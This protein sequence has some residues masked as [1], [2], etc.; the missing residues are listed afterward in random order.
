MVRILLD[1]MQ[2]RYQ[3]TFVAGIDDLRD[4]RELRILRDRA[5]VRLEV[6][7]DMER[8]AAEHFKRNPAG[9]LAWK[10]AAASAVAAGRSFEDAQAAYSK[11]LKASD[12]SS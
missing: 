12:A 5:K 7:L 4:L 10:D 3:N 11:A 1:K 2:V 8:R 9:F 6:A